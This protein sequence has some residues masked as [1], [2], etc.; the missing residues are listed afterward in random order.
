MWN[1]IYMETDHTF[2]P[3]SWMVIEGSS[4]DNEKVVAILAISTHKS[5]VTLKTA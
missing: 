5:T 3:S 4:L 2:L 1:K